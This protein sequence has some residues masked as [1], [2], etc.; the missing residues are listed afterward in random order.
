MKVT[1]AKTYMP[2]P[3]QLAKSPKNSLKECQNTVPYCQK[4]TPTDCFFRRFCPLG[5]LFL[6]AIKDVNPV[7]ID[8]SGENLRI[9]TGNISEKMVIVV[10]LMAEKTTLKGSSLKATSKIGN[11][12]LKKLARTRM[13]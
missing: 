7:I 3:T 1:G 6:S 12:K 5:R 2:G 10:N 11:G 8:I 9:F 13:I 4:Y